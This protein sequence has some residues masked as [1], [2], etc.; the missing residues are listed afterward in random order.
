MKLII[1]LSSK[2]ASKR[3]PKTHKKYHLNSNIIFMCHKVTVHPL[4]IL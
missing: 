1:Q 2:N 4:G 3:C